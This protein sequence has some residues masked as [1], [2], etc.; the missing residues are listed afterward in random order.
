MKKYVTNISNDR[1]AV[2]TTGSKVCVF[3]KG[4][5][6][7]AVFRDLKYAY[8]A[9][10]SPDGARL[11]VKTTDGVL[12]LYSLEDMELI[13]KIRFG[14]APQDNGFCFTGGGDR[15]INVAMHEG[16]RRYEI[17]A[18][19]AANLTEEET[20]FVSENRSVLEVEYADGDLYVLGLEDG[21]RPFVGRLF[22]GRIDPF[23]EITDNDWT[24]LSYW[25][26]LINRRGCTEASYSSSMLAGLSASGIPVS[27]D[28]SLESIKKW[29]PTVKK[30]FDKYSA[31]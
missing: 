18:Y 9:A 27:S 16:P 21:T 12:A 10:F 6:E 14:A 15:L 8:D 30:L 4:G 2:G 22:E 17:K 24:F 23:F 26:V 19:N 1:F 7:I 29:G 13:G 3:D 5:K 25:A 11:A 20:L 28:Y 31:E